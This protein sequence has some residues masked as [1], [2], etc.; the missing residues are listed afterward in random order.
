MFIGNDL[1]PEA[2]RIAGQRLATLGRHQESPQTPSK[3]LERNDLLDFTGR[4]P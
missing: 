4:R 2:V 1:N 3:V